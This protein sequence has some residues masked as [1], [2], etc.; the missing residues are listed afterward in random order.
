MRYV[1]FLELAH[2]RLNPATYLEIGI[3]TGRSLGRSRCRSVGVDPAFA[4]KEELHCDVSLF[5]TTSDEYFSRPDPLEPTGGTPF[6]LAFIDGLHFFEFALRD[7][8]NT[9]RYSSTRGVIFFD[10]MMPNSVDEAARLKHTLF[11]TGD[12]YSM[13]EV[14]RRYRPDLTVLTIDVRPTGLLL[15]T[16]LDP[17]N[18]TLSDHYT[19]ILA[20]YRKPDPQPVPDA[21]V[22]RFGAQ[23]P[24]RV[25]DSGLFELLADI[26]PGTP[27]IEVQQR[28]SGCLSDSLGLAYA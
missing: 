8:I 22:D 6:D 17:D 19:E 5:R 14:L 20:E 24:E 3:R 18:T 16:G 13:V 28:L 23:S 1:D 12:V 21:L 15:V 9:E 27:A 26:P 25:A 4:I 11:W 2:R 10:D 7:F